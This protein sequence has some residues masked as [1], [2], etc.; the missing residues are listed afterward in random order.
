MSIVCPDVKTTHILIIDDIPGNI[1]VLSELLERQGYQVL[2][3]I[4]GSLGLSVARKIIPDL[5]LLDI[6]M[7]GMDGYEICQLLKSDPLTAQIPVIFISALGD[8]FDKIR[9]F[10]VGGQD[11]ITKPFAVEEV[12]ARIKNQL[13]LQEQHRQ[14]REEVSLRI[15]S[16]K[17]LRESQELLSQVLNTS[18]DGIAAFRVIRSP[19]SGSVETFQCRI[20]NPKMEQILH[21]SNNDHQNAECSLGLPEFFQRANPQILEELVRVVETGEVL[22]EDLTYMDSGTG[23]LKCYTLRATKLEDG[24]VI[25]LRDIT[26]RKTLELELKRQVHLDGLTQ[27]ANRRCF[28]ESLERE[29]LRCGRYQHPLAL[30]LCDVDAFKIYNDTYGHV[31]G[32]ACLIQVAKVLTSQA[33]RSGDLVARYG[34]EEFAVLLPET[35]LEGAKYLAEKIR[36]C[37]HDL[38]L[39]HSFSPVQPFVTLSFGV[40]VQVP[41]LRITEQ[42]NPDPCRGGSVCD[43]YNQPDPQSK[44]SDRSS[45]DPNALEGCN[46]HHRDQYPGYPNINPDGQSY[47]NI[48]PQSFYPCD[49]YQD[50]ASY[51]PWINLESP[52]EP[53]VELPRIVPKGYPEIESTDN[54][55]LVAWAD[56]ALYEAKGRGRD[57]VVA[58]PFVSHS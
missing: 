47:P 2:K 54:Q 49:P 16:E 37:F 34:G 18:Q 5:I 24:V 48:E 55:Q 44:N 36:Q 46:P 12:I 14:L 8:P 38:Q 25:N 45:L 32:D 30:I 29:W 17:K 56:L 41:P 39:P 9:A 1:R 10:D 4:N 35:T 21:G 13:T 33:C 57:Q 3:A 52:I 42:Q 27:V 26:S 43:R 20:A 19:G 23:K 50:E 22:S 28:D 31:M 11:Y 6:K 53:S 7:P 40:A 58:Y 51:S 15:A